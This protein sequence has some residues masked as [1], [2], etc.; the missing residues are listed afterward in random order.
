[1]QE[2]ESVTTA[3][4][5]SGKLFLYKEPELL[6][7]ETHGHMGL[8]PSEH[9]FDH[10]RNERVVPLTM[11]EFSNALRHYPII[12]ANIDRPQPLAAL[13]VLD[14]NNLFVDDDGKW[15]PMCH[16]PMYLRCYPLAFAHGGGDRV[17]V[18][19]DR[20]ADTVTENAEFPFFDGDKPSEH[21][22]QLMSLC[23]HYDAERRRTY[24]FCQKLVELELLTPLRAT[25]TPEGATE[26]VPLA[27]YVGIDAQKIDALD[28]EQIFELHKKGY[29]SAIYLQLYSLENW[30]H[31][32]ARREAQ[33]RT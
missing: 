12:F 3:G 16:V 8:T 1:M 22:E 29:L 28:K 27:E 13:G 17:A 21:T 15:D 9:P 4:T 2:T 19:V 20:S 31:L 26:A 30:R 14:D 10:V 7:P 25:Y 5:V 11:A 32:M 24:D 18:V 33:G 6:A 23:A